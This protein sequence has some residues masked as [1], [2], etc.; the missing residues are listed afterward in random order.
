MRPAPPEQFERKARG[1]LKCGRCGHDLP[2]FMF[3]PAPGYRLGFRSTCRP[4][5][6]GQPA[7]P[8]EPHARS[9]KVRTQLVRLQ[10]AG[11]LE[12]RRCRL[13]LPTSEFARK[14]SSTT[15]YDSN[16]RSCNRKVVV[17]RLYGLPH[18][19]YEAR[20]AAPCAI[21]GA[22]ATH[23]DHDHETGKAR[24]G[25]CASCNLGLGQ[26]MDDPARLRAAATYLEHHN[27]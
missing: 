13:E 1:F 3:Q 16:C 10:R 2:L 4:C 25:L 24:S 12:C 15:G 20:L 18:D 26:F 14:A 17:E 5:Q 11:L 6:A 21:C 9:Y 19:E 23:L 7:R 8:N 27:G 22:P